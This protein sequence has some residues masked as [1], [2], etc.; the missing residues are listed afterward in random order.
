MQEECQEGGGGGI[1]LA[2]VR[3]MKNVRV[4][5]VVEA[6]RKVDKYGGRTGQATTTL[7]RKTQEQEEERAFDDE[8]DDVCFMTR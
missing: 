2:R 3:A 8:D 1:M 4:D 5:K 7:P 6:S